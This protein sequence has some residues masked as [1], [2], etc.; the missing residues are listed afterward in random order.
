[1]KNRFICWL[2]A[3]LLCLSICGCAAEPPL[4]ETPVEDFR[5][6]HNTNTPCRDHAPSQCKHL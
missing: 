4:K 1:M 5:I 3:V 6:S 2:L